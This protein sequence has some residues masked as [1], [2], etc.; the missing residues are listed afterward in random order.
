MNPWKSFT[1]VS[2]TALLFLMFSAVPVVAGFNVTISSGASSGGSWSGATP[3]V[4]TA[5]ASGATVSVAELQSRLSGGGATVDVGSSGTE[6]GDI[7]IAAPISWIGNTLTFTASRNIQINGVM[8]A[9]GSASLNMTGTPLCGFAPG[10]GFGGRVDYSASG[11]LTINGSP[12]TVITSLGSATSSNDG[13]LQGIKGALSGKYALGANIDAATT[14]GWNFGAGFTPLGKSPTGFSG[15]FDGLG[16]SINRLHVTRHS[17]YGA[18][19][20]FGD[21]SGALLRNVGVNISIFSSMYDGYNIGGL[22]GAMSGGSINNCYSSGTV[23]G[24]STYAVYVGGLVGYLDGGSISGSYSSAAVTAFSYATGVI[25]PFA[26]SGGLVGVSSNGSISNC[27]SSGSS[28]AFS[29]SAGNAAAASGGLVGDF[30]NGGITNSY[31]SGPVTTKTM[32]TSSVILYP[33]SG[34]LVGRNTGGSISYSY[35]TSPVSGATPCGLICANS[36]SIT[37][38]FWDTQSSGAATSS[39]GTGKTTSQMKSLATFSGWDISEA[40]GSSSDWRIVDGITYPLLRLFSRNDV[41]IRNCTPGNYDNGSAC[42]PC[43]AGSYQPGGSQT[44]CIPAPVGFFAPAGAAAPTACAAGSYQDL[45]GQ[46]TCKSCDLATYQ[47]ATGQS[48]CIQAPAGTYVNITGATT[49]TLC[50]AGTYQSLPSQI[51]CNQC[52]PG[53]YQS[54][55]GQASCIAAP[56][57]YFVPDT[58]ATTLTACSSGTYQSNTGA[59]SCT[60]CPAGTVQSASGQSACVAIPKAAASMVIDQSTNP[61]TLF[62]AI[63]TEGVY[64]SPDD[65]ASWTVANGTA[66]NNLTNLRVKVLARSS[67]GVLF[68]ATY[69]D[70]VFKSSDNAVSWSVCATQPGNLNVLSLEIDGAG[71]IYAGTENGIYAS[72]DGC[73]TWTG[74]NDG[75]P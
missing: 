53:Q 31:S 4:W 15:V 66:P 10:G 64:K 22:V 54:T 17:A 70:G 59:F 33:Y 29:A 67:A 41:Y 44:S 12:Y 11:A 19:G 48:S 56:V 34:G 58:G 8:T 55:P 46:S 71:K 47:N 24:T 49:P 45:T 18:G 65:G 6:N 60:A 43:A 5:S 9:T 68:A 37:D 39:G 7:T 30:I 38:S 14:W 63:D 1:A 28:T 27:Y 42:A 69:G 20:L 25:P 21:T 13:T 75:L 52:L 74:M 72:G 26:Y 57:G 23:T 2:V 62:A 51:E 3:D 32:S 35:S 16:H 73:G 36:G 50:S 61:A 40:A